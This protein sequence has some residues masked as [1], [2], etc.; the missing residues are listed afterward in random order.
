MYHL[1]FCNSIQEQMNSI[2]DNI[3]KDL[4]NSFPKF[5]C[6]WKKENTRAIKEDAPITQNRMNM[7]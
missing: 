6:F 3:T 4:V 7:K 5:F 1:L 2:I